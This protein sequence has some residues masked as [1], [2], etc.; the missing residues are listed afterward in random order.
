MFLFS[1]KPNVL[2][3]FLNQKKNMML[4]NVFS[5]SECI[6]FSKSRKETNHQNVKRKTNKQS[7]PQIEYNQLNGVALDLLRVVMVG[8]VLK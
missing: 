8:L 1:F 3:L 2:L 4:K 6:E 7:K 5:A